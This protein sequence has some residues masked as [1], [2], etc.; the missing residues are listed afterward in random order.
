MTRTTH[1]RSLELPPK[2]RRDSGFSSTSRSS[3]L[4][5][6]VTN[7]DQSPKNVIPDQKTR[8]LKTVP[9]EDIWKEKGVPEKNGR[10]C[11]PAKDYTV[12]GTDNDDSLQKTCSH[13]Q[14]LL[15]S[16]AE[17]NQENIDDN[18]PSEI[19]C[20]VDSNNLYNHQLR[21]S[22]TY[23]SICTKGRSTPACVND[24]KEMTNNR[25][26]VAVIKRCDDLINQLQD[27]TQ[28]YFKL[29][30]LYK[31]KKRLFYILSVFNC[32]LILICLLFLPLIGLLIRKLS[33]PN[34]DER[35]LTETD[36]AEILRNHARQ[37]QLCFNC[38]LLMI[39]TPFSLGRLLDVSQDH[40]KCCFKSIISVMK[41]LSRVFHSALD[42]R[43][44]PVESQI[45]VLNKRLLQLE[46]GS[47][48][49]TYA[50]IGNILQVLA[51]KEKTAMFLRSVKDAPLGEDYDTYNKFNKL[52]WSTDDQ[53]AILRGD[54]Q[55]SE[56]QMSIQVK[57]EAY[58]FIYVKVQ[59]KSEH[60]AQHRTTLPL[61]YLIYRKR[62]SIPTYI[63]EAKHNC[64]FND[65]LQEHSSTSEMI[66]HLN[67][68]DEI[69]VNVDDSDKQFLST[70]GGAH[71]IGLFEI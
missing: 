5:Y 47:A 50:I 24:C 54:V 58:Y 1:L 46:I 38:T 67:R 17:V 3:E 71:T 36:E 16:E 59:F 22:H 28:K 66:L 29:E 15:A 40:E 19:F 37:Y 41:S 27:F 42:E 49:D 57:A 53:S 7:S 52:R 64:V 60:R 55:L 51:P 30:D 6:L 56:D 11:L 32:I 63:H 23:E 21:K 33:G 25:A 20:K 69:F 18:L 14:E 65:V 34:D 35:V 26:D 43:T 31:K 13:A 12:S 45:S 48:P 70:G 39:G 8:D 9:I 2:H 61:S 10:E 44:E 62:G 4:E 68:D